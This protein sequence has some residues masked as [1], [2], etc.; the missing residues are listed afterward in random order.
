[1]RTII[2]TVVV[3][4]LLLGIVLPAVAQT[5][6]ISL[7]GAL[8]ARLRDPG[9]FKTVDER[10]A[11]VDKVLIEVISKED[12]QHPQVM[13]RQK[14]NLWTVYA[15]DRPVMAVYPAEAAANKMTEKQLGLQWA[16]KL[17]AQLP[18]A[19]PCS[20]LP[21]E[22]LGYGK[23]VKV[24][25]TTPVAVKPATAAP[26]AKPATTVKP[27]AVKPVTAAK[28]AAAT[29]K[30]V[31]AVVKPAAA[32]VRPTSTMTGGESGAMLL[33]VDAMR[34]AREMNDQDWTAQKEAMARGLYG[35]L[36][37][38]LTGKGEAPKLPATTVVKP[39]TVK[40]AA[41]KPVVAKPAVA[42]PTAKPAAKPVATVVKPVTAKPVVAKPAT[43]KP[44]ATATKP[45]TKPTAVIKPTAATVDA[46]MVKVPQK[47]RIRAKFAAVKGPFDKLKAA[48]PQSATAVAKMLTDSR[49]AFAYGNFDESERQVDAA[50]SALGVEF[51][52]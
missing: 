37:Y 48:D 29:A 47:N 1:M 31:A 3:M 9:S 13:L 15:W 11:S 20:K 45:A 19:T 12:T 33:I 26:P 6:D 5:A 39:V 43:A 51:K 23:P 35:D 24:A 10:A 17:R 25:A 28:P 36:S 22:Q 27:V 16:N 44:V 46:S 30:P 14:G 34:T 8:V 4:V 41:V 40:P 7:G 38:Y 21:P 18:K 50:L 52:E 49:Q 2:G 32:T 42:K